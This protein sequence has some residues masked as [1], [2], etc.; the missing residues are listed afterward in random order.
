MLSFSLKKTPFSKL[1]RLFSLNLAVW[2]L[3]IQSQLGPFSS[4]AKLLSTAR[5]IVE[6]ARKCDIFS[7]KLK[8]LV[9]L[10]RLWADQDL[11]SISLLSSLSHFALELF[12]LNE[13]QLKEE[14]L[15]NLPFWR[16]ASDPTTS[17]STEKSLVYQL[18]KRKKFLELS[19]LV[20]CLL[21]TN[22]DSNSQ[23]ELLNYAQEFLS[24][25]ENSKAKAKLTKHLIL[26][27][28][29]NNFFNEAIKFALL[30]PH[31][32]EEF[33]STIIMIL[34]KLGQSAD[35][36]EILY[37]MS[38]LRGSISKSFGEKFGDYE[39]W[40][41][42]TATFRESSRENDAAFFV[43]LQ[44]SLFITDYDLKFDCLKALLDVQVDKKNFPAALEA[45]QVLE[46]FFTL[47]D[48]KQIRNFLSH[49]KSKITGTPENEQAPCYQEFLGYLNKLLGETESPTETPEDSNKLN[50]S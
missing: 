31:T 38:C 10:T 20:F 21:Q 11:L 50:L 17:F 14:F 22:I 32:S 39:I 2:K 47:F 34:D 19:F 44:A 23:K 18:V 1:A 35:N 3:L 30:V 6:T 36:Q 42:V 9:A 43:S 26:F 46:Q 37:C 25:A 16:H 48:E 4:S 33:L 7:V 27:A 49:I 15:K 24:Q 29:N 13:Q 45:L 12:N 5:Q 41:Y 28:V 40:Q 8:A